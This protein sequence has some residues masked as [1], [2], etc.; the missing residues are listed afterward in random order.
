VSQSHRTSAGQTH[1]RENKPAY[2]QHIA[3]KWDPRWPRGTPLFP[4]RFISAPLGI[5][6]QNLFL[7]LIL[8]SFCAPGFISIIV[9]FLIIYSKM[10]VLSDFPLS[11][12]LPLSNLFL[13]FFS[14][15]RRFF[16]PPRAGFASRWPPRRPDAERHCGDR[17]RPPGVP[18]VSSRPLPPRP[19]ATRTARVSDPL[20]TDPRHPA[21]FCLRIRGFQY[22]LIFFFARWKVG[23]VSVPPPFSKERPP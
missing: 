7:S 6:D 5:S 18:R 19:K 21:I 16:P 1:V 17:P 15:L 13:P 14:C 4:F 23:R 12:S 9:G 22:T 3:R 10:G 8:Q 2:T 20:L 11:S